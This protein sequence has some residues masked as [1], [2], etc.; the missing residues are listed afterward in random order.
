MRR[1]EPNEESHQILVV[2]PGRLELPRPC[3]HWILSP[4]YPPVKDQSI[5]MTWKSQF[6][7]SG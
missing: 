7:V 5:G 2:P 3:G 4:A 6:K 1:T